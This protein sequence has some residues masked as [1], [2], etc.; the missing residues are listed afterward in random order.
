M[1]P[2]YLLAVQ[3]PWRALQL[4]P[5]C[6]MSRGALPLPCFSRASGPRVGVALPA[7]GSYADGLDLPD[8]RLGGGLGGFVNLDVMEVLQLSAGPEVTWLTPTNPG[9]N[10]LPL[11]MFAPGW[12]IRY[13]WDEANMSV[14]VAACTRFVMFGENKAVVDKLSSEARV[15]FQLP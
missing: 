2:S 5:A 4:A 10:L 9:E 6:G 13:D 8:V 14:G 11:K 12:G 1:W 15:E 7:L 3:A